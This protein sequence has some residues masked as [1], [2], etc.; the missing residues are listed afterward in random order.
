MSD[1]HGTEALPTSGVHDSSG[2][3]EMLAGDSDGFGIRLEKGVSD[4]F[5]IA[6]S[7]SDDDMLAGDSDHVAFKLDKAVSIAFRI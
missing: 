5:L 4:C 2:D 7:S 3:S 1:L 6:Q